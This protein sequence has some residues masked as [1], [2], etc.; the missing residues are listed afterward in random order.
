MT[1]HNPFNTDY[2]PL[3]SALVDK[4]LLEAPMITYSGQKSQQADSSWWIKWKADYVT[5]LKNSFAKFKE[6]ANRQN[7][8][9]GTWLKNN[10]DYFKPEDYGAS[11]GVSVPNAPD[12]RSAIARIK[13]AIPT[14]IN[15]PVLNRLEVTTDGNNAV[16]GGDNGFF[17]RIICPDYQ[18]SGDDFL[19]FCRGYY[20]GNDNKRTITMRQ[21]AA[22]IPIMHNYCMSF[23]QLI[24]ALQNQVQQ[25][26]TFVNQDALTGQ[27]NPSDSAEKQ[28]Q[29]L[30]QSQ[31]QQTQKASSNPNNNIVQHAASDLDYLAF[32][33]LFHE[34]QTVAGAKTIGNTGTGSM[35]KM[36]NTVGAARNVAGQQKVQ[37]QN[38]VK[39]IQDQN[40]QKVNAKQ[41][42]LKKKQFAATI[43]RDVINCKLSSAG[44]IY[45]DFITT[46]QVHIHGV[47]EKIAKQNQKMADKQQREAEK[48]QPRR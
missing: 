40:K 24:N 10:K 33:Y 25:I 6:Y 42:A 47:Q 44:S 41:L 31:M 26:I 17:Y 5:T 38:Q 2:D 27:Y 48:A 46:L 30:Q 16:S 14:T 11:V 39:N 18:G 1:N 15:G 35:A 28:A 43:L 37:Q 4:F 19:N 22:Y 36:T 8:K 34:V 29:A 21:S 13:T 3:I 9:Y 20:S 45:S 12:Y 32:D 23:P 7:L